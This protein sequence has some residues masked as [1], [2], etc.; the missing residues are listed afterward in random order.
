MRIALV[1][2]GFIAAITL[3]PW[4]TAIC[5]VLLALRYRAWEAILLGLFIDL[6]WQPL[7]AEGLFHLVP[8]FT[9]S[10]MLV[11]WAFEPVRTQ[12]LN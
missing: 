5:V 6:T 3:P 9:L 7:G 11:V 8:I 1:V 2:A 4:V 10:C 12:F